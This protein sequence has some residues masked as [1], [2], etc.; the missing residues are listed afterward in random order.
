M[1]NSKQIRVHENDYRGM[2]ITPNKVDTSK[3]CPF[4]IIEDGIG[5]WISLLKYIDFDNFIYEATALLHNGD[6]FVHS[7]AFD[8]YNGYGHAKFAPRDIIRNPTLEEMKAIA[9]T[10]KTSGFYFNRKTNE[11]KKIEEDLPF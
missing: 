5:I 3:R 9:Q 8:L 10:L 4:Q 11:L 2:Y 7:W 1:N 6:R